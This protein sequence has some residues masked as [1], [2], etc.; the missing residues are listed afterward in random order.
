MEIPRFPFNP[1]SYTKTFWDFLL[2]LLLLF[3]TFAVPFL[4]AFGGEVDPK[5][6]LSAYDIF[7]LCLDVIFC[8]DIIVTFFTCIH[9]QGVYVTDLTTIAK[10]YLCG[11]FWIDMPGSIPFDKIIIYTSA[12]SD[13]GPILKI[14][15]FIRILKLARAV[16]FMRK[17]DQL[18]EKDRTGSMK[19]V[20]NVFRSVLIMIFSAHFLG[21]MFILLR[22][23]N[24]DHLDDDQ[25]NWMDTF[26]SELRY[27]SAYERYIACL[28]WAIATV[29]TIGPPPRA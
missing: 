12:S 11:W 14:L 24:M 3:T 1:E 5:A 8:V 20:L 13:M 10:D 26:D 9:L 22:D 18:E 16:K 17:L 27:Q 2:M 29:S 23:L 21:C 15:K 6:P 19:T 7:D 28:Y 4:L 25:A